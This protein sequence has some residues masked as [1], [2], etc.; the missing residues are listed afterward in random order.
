MGYFSIST[1]KL[2]DIGRYSRCLEKNEIRYHMDADRVSSHTI[3][4]NFFMYCTQEAFETVL[5]ELRIK[6]KEVNT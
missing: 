2:D 4:Y 3:Q 6:M 5:K 1:R